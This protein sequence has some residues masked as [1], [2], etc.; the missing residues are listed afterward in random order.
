[1]IEKL[2]MISK[3][4]LL[5]IILGLLIVSFLLTSMGGYLFFNKKDYIAEVNGYKIKTKDLQRAFNEEIYYQKKLLGNKFSSLINNK[6][7]ILEIKKQIFLKILNQVLFDQYIKKINIIINDE[8]VKQAIINQSM[9]QISGIFN[10]NKYNNIIEN[11]GFTPNEYAEYVRN[12][13]AKNKF[14]HALLRSSFVL[15]NEIKKIS[16]FLCEE[17]II[18]KVI[19]NKNKLYEKHNISFKEIKNFYQQNKKL[20]FEPEK[21]LVNYIK[22]PLNNDKIKINSTKI[23]LLYK[24]LNNSLHTRYKF[25]AIVSTTKSE[26]DKILNNLKQYG[27]TFSKISNLKNIHLPF[28]NQNGYIGW[29][30]SSFIPSFMK[31]IKLNKKGT[32][33]NVIQYFGHFI[34]LKLDDIEYKKIKFISENEIRLAINKKMIWD[35]LYKFNKQLNN[36]THKKPISFEKILSNLELKTYQTFW[37]D[38]TNFPKDLS[39]TKIKKF[40]LNPCLVRHLQSHKQYQNYDIINDDDFIYLI[41]S[42]KYQ[43]AKVKSLQQVRHNIINIIKNNTFYKNRKFNIVNILN[44]LK[45]GKTTLTNYLNVAKIQHKTLHQNLYYQ[46]NKI[47]IS[48]KE[49]QLIDD[50]FNAKQTINNKPIWGVSINNDGTKILFVID[51]IFTNKISRNTILKIKKMLIEQN[52]E[53]LLNTILL[54]LQKNA[55]INYGTIKDLYYE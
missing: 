30:E 44:D 26:A 7:Y 45:S 32:F 16:N 11:M 31:S 4:I 12:I 52:V 55:K 24:K 46:L 23:K 38:K 37:F 54:N 8:Q 27:A 36:L 43:S 29:I 14:I 33:S 17:R 6:N 20:F 21:F 18:R 50:V 28:I 25:S 10:N 53:N 48:N 3:N 51:K 42:I 41:N 39:S 1:M 40:L 9:F 34:I 22:L 13:I 5:K 35:S 15:N 19:F 49:K 47:T 2:R